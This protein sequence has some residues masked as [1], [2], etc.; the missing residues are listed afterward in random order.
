MIFVCVTNV[1]KRANV[2]S[3]E[4]NNIASLLHNLLPLLTVNTF[5]CSVVKFS[6]VNFILAVI[7]I[8]IRY[9]IMKRGYLRWYCARPRDRIPGQYT[10]LD[11]HTTC[12]M[13]NNVLCLVIH[14]RLQNLMADLCVNRSKAKVIVNM[15]SLSHVTSPFFPVLSPHVLFDS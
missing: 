3:W 10:H 8:T 1:A 11:G 2:K 6:R 15:I 14:V 7:L 5:R 9:V 12:I 13:I 4:H